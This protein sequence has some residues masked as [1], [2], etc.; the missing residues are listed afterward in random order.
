M[1][2]LLKDD[3]D[4]NVENT[5][6]RLEA[7]KALK[8]SNFVYKKDEQSDSVWNIISDLHVELIFLYNKISVKLLGYEE[9]PKNGSGMR[10]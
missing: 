3:V 6:S 1:V 9:A 5:L 8:E 2:D 4:E 10:I 7:L